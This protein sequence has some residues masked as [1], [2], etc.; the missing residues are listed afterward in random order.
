[1][2][3]RAKVLDPPAAPVLSAFTGAAIEDASELESWVLSGTELQ[4][5]L[6]HSPETGVAC[7]TSVATRLSAATGSAITAGE[8]GS[9]SLP[10]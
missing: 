3:G 8:L 7:A 2:G 5:P 10:P 1:M 6:L 4:A 9:Q